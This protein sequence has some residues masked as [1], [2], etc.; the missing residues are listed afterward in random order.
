MSL[1]ILFFLG[2]CT[3]LSAQQNKSGLI[4][5]GICGDFM[6]R[7]VNQYYLPAYQ[8]VNIYSRPDATSKV[9]YKTQSF[10][11]SLKVLEVLTSK[12]AKFKNVYG[13]WCKVSFP[14]RGKRYNVYVPSQFL[15]AIQLR[16]GSKVYML[17]IENYL[18][19]I[20]TLSLKILN[21][22]SLVLL[23]QFTPS[24]NHGYTPIESDTINRT[25]EGYMEMGI[26]DNRGFEDIDYII[27]VHNGVD[28]C[29]YWNGNK[30]LLIKDNKVIKTVEDGALSEAGIYYYGYEHL[31]P[32]DSLG[33]KGILKKK[34]WFW[35]LINDS[36]AETYDAFVKYKWE[37]Y[38]FIKTDSTYTGKFINTLK[39]NNEQ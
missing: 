8:H 21:N 36:M 38:Q 15:S 27:K 13:Y 30:N 24:S 9:F 35:E 10:T 31:F 1:L 26:Y 28:A 16:H 39:N 6:N 33:E 19:D 25:L 2:F 37:N 7:E 23:Y 4:I 11:D 12:Y 17:S 14:F 5:N 29:S 3:Q 32:S 18:N 22:Y 34:I 20:F